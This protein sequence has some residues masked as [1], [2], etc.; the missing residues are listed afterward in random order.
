MDA[1]CKG[2]MVVW[3]C[4]LVKLCALDLWDWVCLPPLAFH[5]L[6]YGLELKLPDGMRRSDP[7]ES[8]WM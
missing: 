5:D 8:C 7:W 1:T 3:S 2:M 4:F 6:I